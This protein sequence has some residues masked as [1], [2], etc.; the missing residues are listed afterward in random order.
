MQPRCDPDL[1]MF[2]PA[3]ARG[4]LVA[5]ESLP[6]FS[7][8]AFDHHCAQACQARATQVVE[9]A[10]ARDV[11]AEG[12]PVKSAS[13]E[14]S[15]PMGMR[16]K[17][18][19]LKGRLWVGTEGAP[20]AALKQAL[21]APEQ[22]TATPFACGSAFEAGDIH[23]LT[24][25]GLVVES[26]GTKAVVRS[27]SL[28]AGHDVLLS[29][30]ESMGAADETAFQHRFGDRA[31]RVGDIYRVSAGTGDDWEDAYDFHFEGG[32]LVRVD[33]WIGC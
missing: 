9:A 3:A 32:R 18:F 31:E 8:E 29:N 20:W 12:S 33:Y 13:H 11:C 4:L 19:A 23:Q 2:L 10:F 24:Y 26:D 6:G 28:A 1:A 27:I 16:V 21:G 7:E 25:P 17:G 22:D 5:A 30:G 15:A 14:A